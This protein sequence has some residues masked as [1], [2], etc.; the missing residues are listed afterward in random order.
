MLSSGWLTSVDTELFPLVDQTCAKYCFISLKQPLPSN[1]NRLSRA[2]A[3][4]LALFSKGPSD[5]QDKSEAKN[6]WRG[7]EAA[8]YSEYPI[9]GLDA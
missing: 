3:D 9:T 5:M 1:A 7:R 8:V 2:L 4:A 6:K